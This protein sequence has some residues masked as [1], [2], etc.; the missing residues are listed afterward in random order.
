ML[1][2]L[3]HTFKHSF[4][5]SLGNLSVKIIG[6]IL[7]PVYTSHLTTAEY[8]VLSILETTSLILQIFVSL[9]IANSMMRWW[10]DAK[11]DFERKSYVF[12]SFSFLLIVIIAFNILFQPFT[13]FF[14]RIF[15]KNE[16]Y[17]FYFMI[18][19]LTVSFEVLTKYI[20]SI[21]RILEHSTKYI[22][23]SSIKLLVT[24]S[25]TIYFV[26]VLR[27]G[28]KGIIISQLV[29]AVFLTLIL[30]PVLFKNTV[31]KF[32]K[33]QLK[34]MLAFSV[35]LSFSIISF[36]VFNMGD[37]YVLKFISGDSQV[38]I[39]SLAYKISGFL[40][41]F[42][43]QSFQ[44]AFMPIA[45]KMYKEPNAK[46]FFSKILTYL[47][48]G[49]TF[50]ALGL[51]LFAPEVVMLFSP[52]NKNYWEAGQYVYLINFNIIILGMRY[53]FSLSF[54]IS[55]KTKIMPVY[56]TTFAT[57]NILL[58]F[59]TIKYWQITGAIL[60]SIFSN[61]LL[62]YVFYRQNRKIFPIKYEI[63]K[64]ILVI[65]VGILLFLSV[66]PF[67]HSPL[68]L[69]I[70]VKTFVILL[71]PLIIYFGGFLEPIEKETINNALRKWKNPK[72]WK[73]NFN[74]TSGD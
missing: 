24:L 35:P 29:G 11:D 36:F 63:K 2:K 21:L 45:L 52:E 17:S 68:L 73:Q 72:K 38:G 57:L 51:A 16:D 23:T 64:D 67:N 53:I 26:V 37:R 25:L 20:L 46:R 1:Q 14:S 28:V 6:L 9:S 8:G 4:I 15:F 33:D 56:V 22:I 31:L 39:Y 74:K 65:L 49:L 34:P 71:F 41:F 30:L 50:G 70:A 62:T 43:L 3:K 5:Y 48:I 47:T 61:L 59:F 44:A 10:A 12:T 18:L 42:V 60:S 19:F 69:K 66:L 27:W 58:D 13:D 7:L 32:R 55:K 40:N 54:H